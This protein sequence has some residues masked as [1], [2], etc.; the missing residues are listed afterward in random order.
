MYGRRHG[1]SSCQGGWWP[2]DVL[3][4]ARACAD[5]P[6]ACVGLPRGRWHAGSSAARDARA[7]IR[8]LAGGWRTVRRAGEAR[9]PSK[10]RAARLGCACKV[11]RIS[12]EEHIVKELE[13]FPSICVH[14]KLCSS[15]QRIRRKRTCSRET[16]IAH[17]RELSGS[18]HCRASILRWLQPV[19]PIRACPHNSQQAARSAITQGEAR[20]LARHSLHKEGWCKCEA[21]AKPRQVPW[22]TSC[23]GPGERGAPWM[24]QLGPAGLKEWRER[25]NSPCFSAVRA[26]KNKPHRAWPK[27]G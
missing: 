26:L 15:R 11:G 6:C 9:Q 7:C 23:R 3:L 12:P 4:R 18:T 25:V 20:R 5:G 13:V 24:Q 17:E 14:L 16:R 8:V 21:C 22:H 2:R 19:S 1:Q 10:D 27:P